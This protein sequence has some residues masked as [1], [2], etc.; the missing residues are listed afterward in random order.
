VIR[1]VLLGVWLACLA[2]P[3]YAQSKNDPVLAEAKYEEARKFYNLGEFD[4]ALGLYR[5]SYLLSGEPELLFNIGQCQRQL[6]QYEEARNSYKAYLRDVPDS[7][8]RDEIEELIASVEAKIGT[9]ESQPVVIKE[10]RT[11]QP[12]EPTPTK[13][14]KTS[15]GDALKQSTTAKVGLATAGVGLLLGGVSLSL[16]SKANDATGDILL[17]TQQKRSAIAVAFTSDVLFLVGV[18][19]VSAG[20]VLAR[21]KAP[22]HVALSLD[23]SGINAAFSWEF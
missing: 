19:C 10:E 12:F 2:A 17:A 3:T 15:L 9:A 21:Q 1:H 5:E 22:Q 16:A 7:T 23:P 20:W 13:R 14:T 6:G 18:G 4:I 11:T 8:A